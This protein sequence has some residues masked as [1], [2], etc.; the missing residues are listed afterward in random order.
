MTAFGIYFL[1]SSI[2][3]ICFYGIYYF[4]LKNETWF[5]LNRWYL[6]SAVL[7]SISIPLFYYNI[8]VPVLMNAAVE[9]NPIIINTVPV[10]EL[11]EV[12]GN[13]YF[14]F[15]DLWNFILGV[16][17]L[18]VV[19]Y[20]SNFIKGLLQ[21]SA[22]YKNGKKE[23]KN[24]ITYV[25]GENDSSVFS[26]FNYIFLNHK[27]SN[28]TEKQQRQII[29]HELAHINDK[30]SF[31]L[32]F[33]ELIKIIFWFNPIIIAYKKSML[34]LHEY[35]ADEKVL[36]KEENPLEYASFLVNQVKENTRVYSFCNHLFHKPIKNRLIM[37]NKSKSKGRN[38]VLAFSFIPALAGMI[39]YFCIEYQEVPVN[40]A[41]EQDNVLPLVEKDSIPPADFKK[42]VLD[43]EPEP[44]KCYGK[45][46][47]ARKEEITSEINIH[48]F[49]GKDAG[50]IDTEIKEVIVKPAHEKWVKKSVDGDTDEMV[51]CLVNVPTEVKKILVVKDIT[52]TNEYETQTFKIKEIA[53]ANEYLDWKEIICEDDITTSLINQVQEK[54]KGLGYDIV[55][56][57]TFDE[58]TKQILYE[59]QGGNDLPIGNLNME[60][61]KALSLEL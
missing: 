19:V 15:S 47:V 6:L 56:N 33:M 28:Y 22:F 49:T 58:A 17:W 36:E 4:L 34:Q 5:Q 26:F 23:N 44:G 61:V 27:I 53:D 38:A 48:V 10:A 12:T 16:Y 52:Q 11:T 51:W 31:D 14:V 42:P 9:E 35:I 29:N 41:E 55:V 20:S 25:V 37:M 60:T 30:H 40:I 54:L 7:F 13:N 2:C 24:G 43:F 57:G 32:L 39:F 21:L 8:D 45:C 59:Y 46:T 18:G 50:N 1:E 3:L